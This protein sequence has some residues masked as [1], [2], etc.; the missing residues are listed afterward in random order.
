MAKF[1]AG[2]RAASN[3]KNRGRPRKYARAIAEVLGPDALEDLIQ[4]A[5]ADAKRTDGPSRT[6]FLSQLQ[7][8]SGARL[9]PG[10]PKLDT[11][12]G[13]VEATSVLGE[14]ARLRKITLTEAEKA[15]Q[16]VMTI[17]LARMSLLARAAEHLDAEIRTAIEQERKLQGAAPAWSPVDK[18]STH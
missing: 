17:A 6:W 4:T 9:P 2:N 12:E 8:D 11:F 10:L 3:P 18:E 7:V 14:M 1:A 5:Y 16:L 13:C 15:L